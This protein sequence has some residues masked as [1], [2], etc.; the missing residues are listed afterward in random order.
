VYPLDAERG[1]LSIDSEWLVIMINKEG[2]AYKAQLV[3]D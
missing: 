2:R 3:C 1:F